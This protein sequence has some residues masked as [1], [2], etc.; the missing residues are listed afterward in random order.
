MS[1]PTTAEP[2]AVARVDERAVARVLDAMRRGER[3]II[4]R[5][6]RAGSYRVLVVRDMT[7]ADPEC[8]A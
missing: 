5:R 2:R 1:A 7:D 3:E 8:A 4:L 6:S